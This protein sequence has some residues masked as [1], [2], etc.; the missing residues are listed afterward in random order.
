MLYY[1]NS[2]YE[3]L[4]P[5]YWNN[6]RTPIERTEQS[7]NRFKRYLHHKPNE[8]KKTLAMKKRIHL[9]L[10]IFSIHSFN[11][12]NF[13]SSKFLTKEAIATSASSGG[14]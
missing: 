12:S 4:F 5:I 7:K 11:L 8:L 3:N 10:K 2:K 6:K 1:L 9:L 13:N 14:I